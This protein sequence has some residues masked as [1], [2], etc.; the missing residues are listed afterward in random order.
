M[1]VQDL[2]SPRYC[3]FWMSKLEMHRLSPAESGETRT[4]G[5]EIISVA[6]VQ[7]SASSHS[8]VLSVIILW[9]FFAVVS[10]ITTKY[11]VNAFNFPFF[12]TVVQFVT[13]YQLTV[14]ILAYNGGG[15][16][17][18]GNV[19]ERTTMT[20]LHT[21]ANVLMTWAL[22]FGKFTDVSF[23][24]T[25]IHFMGAFDVLIT[26]T[27]PFAELLRAMETTTTMLINFLYLGE[28]PSLGSAVSVLPI[29]GGLILCCKSTEAFSLL[30]F[31]ILCA[32]NM[33]FSGRAVGTKVLQLRYPDGVD[34]MA[35]LADASLY[36]LVILIPIMVVF[37]GSG[38]YA[39]SSSFSLEY[40]LSP[41]V[42]ALLLGHCFV[43]AVSNLLSFVVVARTD[44]LSFSVVGVFR[45][46]LTIFC[47]AAYFGVYL[48]QTNLLGMATS[49]AGVLMYMYSKYAGK[50]T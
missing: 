42:L 12:W 16:R 45:R 5:K 36:G 2:A 44:P 18:V 19:L 47:S 28:R 32:S 38:L 43:T 7:P 21:F 13:T 8:V 30:G 34:P 4:S 6:L 20:S 23:S 17:F 40:A 35:L 41:T 15:K 10:A 48:D 14:A 9:L 50:P 25:V 11:L 29:C 24:C 27:A 49:V 46:V 33:C 3:H 26:V 22:L 39:A 37:E 31:L 1:G